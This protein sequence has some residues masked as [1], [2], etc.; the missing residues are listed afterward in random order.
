MA[1]YIG[2]PMDNALQLLRA[3]RVPKL[4]RELTALIGGL[5]FLLILWVLKLQYLTLDFGLEIGGLERDFLILIFSF[6]TGKFII[7][8]SKILIVAGSIMNYFCA[9]KS[10]P[11]ESFKDKIIKYVTYGSLHKQIDVHEANQKITAAELYQGLAKHELLEDSLERDLQSQMLSSFFIS[12]CI[13]GFI[14]LDMPLVRWVSFPLIFFFIIS[15]YDAHR[16]AAIGEYE[17]LQFIAKER[18]NQITKK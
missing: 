10:V 15:W 4:F 6:L 3:F 1:A 9:S 16:N 12:Y 18:Y 14:Y 17:L 5:G 2:P 13:L 11:Q 8:L 7:S